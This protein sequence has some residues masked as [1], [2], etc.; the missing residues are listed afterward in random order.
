MLATLILLAALSGPAGSCGANRPAAPDAAA[1]RRIAETTIRHA[2]AATRPYRLLVEPDRDDARLWVAFQ[3]PRGA[4]SGR[5]G[6]GL[7]FRID[8]CTGA[9]SR[10]HR[11][12]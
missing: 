7:E 6:G 9:V 4:R 12:R 11:A 5:G 8:R 10:M 1:A 3:V 2:G